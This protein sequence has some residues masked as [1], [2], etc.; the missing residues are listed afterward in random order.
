M[1]YFI[2]DKT[3]S[4]ICGMFFEQL[5]PISLFQSISTVNLT[6]LTF[7]E[8]RLENCYDFIHNIFSKRP[9]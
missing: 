3:S 7:F 1:L 8:W 9:N 5:T 6:F 4:D 2:F